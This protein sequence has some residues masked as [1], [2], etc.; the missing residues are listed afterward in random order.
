[1]NVL[2]AAGSMFARA[3]QHGPVKSLAIG[4]CPTR[5]SQVTR[6]VKSGQQPQAIKNRSDRT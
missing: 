4:G 1:L 2:L 5:P 3:R 6:L